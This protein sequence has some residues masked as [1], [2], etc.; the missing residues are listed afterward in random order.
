MR[1]RTGPAAI[2]TLCLGLSLCSSCRN[3]EVEK[4]HTLVFQE[5]RG[6][7]DGTADTYVIE[8]PP[9]VDNNAGRNPYMEITQVLDPNDNK[10]GLVRFELTGLP[11]G[12]AVVEATL[13]LYL[14]G[15]RGGSD[16]KEVDVHE[17]TED[18]EEGEGTGD[19]DGDPGAA[20]VDWMSRP[21]FDPTRLDEAARVLV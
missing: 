9:G 12:V 7:Y 17:V 8:W 21:A 5:G 11:S 13:E 6:G 1:I 19:P 2:L 16:D 20:G 14:L 3:F 15:L 4:E 18:W 10:W